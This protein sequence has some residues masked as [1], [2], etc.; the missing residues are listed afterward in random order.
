M[1]NFTHYDGSSFTQKNFSIKLWISKKI[2]FHY[3]SNVTKTKIFTD[4]FNTKVITLTIQM[5]FTSISRNIDQI[6]LLNRQC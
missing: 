5:C 1:G 4:S 3:K 6:F 2:E